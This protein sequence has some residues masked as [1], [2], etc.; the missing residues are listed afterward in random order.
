MNEDEV[1]KFVHDAVNHVETNY[2]KE[3]LL[4]Q[5]KKLAAWLR[6]KY[7]ISLQRVAISLE[8]KLPYLLFEFI[9]ENEDL[10]ESKICMKEWEN[11]L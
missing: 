8:D 4:K 9:D 3:E 5:R 1:C 7:K 6:S 2:K 11:N 10:K